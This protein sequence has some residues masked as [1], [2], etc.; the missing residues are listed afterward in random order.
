MRVRYTPQ[1]LTDI[2]GIA[3]YVC[4]RNPSA[5]AN[6]ES[7]IRSLIEL[8]ADFPRIG[9]PRPE[10]DARSI[11]VTRYPYTVYYRIEGNEVWIVHVRDDRRRPPQPDDL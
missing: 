7:A 11:G 9:R 5:A 1:A 10:L 3:G 8:L 2:Q 4:R 6:V